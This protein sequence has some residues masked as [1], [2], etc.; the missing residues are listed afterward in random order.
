MF[1]SPKPAEF[2]FSCSTNI[3][4]MVLKTV[5]GEGQPDVIIHHTYRAFPLHLSVGDNYRELNVDQ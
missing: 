2:S 4:W 1:V 5:A 3:V